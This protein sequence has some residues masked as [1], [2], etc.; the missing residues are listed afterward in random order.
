[1][2]CS[3]LET[4]Y[5]GCSIVRKRGMYHLL[6]ES[7]KSLR[8]SEPALIVSRYDFNDAQCNV[9]AKFLRFVAGKKIRPTDLRTLKAV[10]KWEKF[11]KG[12][13]SRED[14]II[15]YCVHGRCEDKLWPAGP[16]IRALRSKD[17]P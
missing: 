12:C 5:H 6:P 7:Q 16:E 2:V 8:R 17:F 9:I 15:I 14:I 3:A 13:S 4:R 1:M 10:E 11:V